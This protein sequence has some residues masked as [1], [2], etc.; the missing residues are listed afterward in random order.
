MTH[1]IELIKTSSGAAAQFPFELKDAFRKAFPSAKWNASAKQWEVGS[2]SVTRLEQWID[3]VKKSGIIEEMNSLE[4]ADI[5]ERELNDLAAAVASIRASIDAAHVS[6][7]RADERKAQ[8]QELSEKLEGMKS[9][10]EAAKAKK[11]ASEEAAEAAAQDV[12]A[13]IAHITTPAQINA[14]RATMKKNFIPKS[15]ATGP[16]NEAQ[17]KLR[18]IRDELEEAGIEC[19]AV[20]LAV[21]ANKNRRDRDYNDLLVDIEFVAA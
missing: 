16:F 1:K 14:L 13:R 3:E 20:S 17:S 2:R 18:A 12:E 5:A 9:D 6:K 15:Y 11:Q 7:E 19:R 21:S 8:S 4:E 10:L